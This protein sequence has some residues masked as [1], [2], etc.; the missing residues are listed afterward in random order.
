MMPFISSQ[1]HHLKSFLTKAL[2]K[3]WPLCLHKG[4]NILLPCSHFQSEFKADFQTLKSSEI[5]RN[6]SIQ[7]KRVLSLLVCNSLGLS[8]LSEPRMPAS[9]KGSN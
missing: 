1:V 9:V 5:L 6:S 7:T 2:Y 3:G 4:L 8:N